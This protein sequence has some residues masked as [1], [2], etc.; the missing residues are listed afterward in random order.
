MIQS[1]DQEFGLSNSTRPGTIK[2]NFFS[3]IIIH[4][5]KSSM[6]CRILSSCTYDIQVRALQESGTDLQGGGSSIRGH[7]APRSCGCRRSQKLGRLRRHHV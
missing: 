5:S 1:Q 7:H 6:E 4:P 3:P 2:H